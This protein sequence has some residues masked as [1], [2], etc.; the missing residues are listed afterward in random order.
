LDYLIVKY[1]DG[2]INLPGRAERIGYSEEWLDA[3]GFG[4]KKIKKK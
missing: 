3:V 1:N 2:Y 4:K